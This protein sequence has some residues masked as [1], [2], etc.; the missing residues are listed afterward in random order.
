MSTGGDGGSGSTGASG[1]SGGAGGSAT[2]T[3]HIEVTGGGG[4]IAASAFA[5]GGSGG[6]GTGGGFL[7][8]VSGRGGDAAAVSTALGGPGSIEA[9]SI[10]IAGTPGD[11]L[12]GAVLGDDGVAHALASAVGARQ[13]AGRAQATGGSG[14]GA[15]ASAS[16]PGVVTGIGADV[17]Q[18]SGNRG[19]LVARAEIGGPATVTTASGTRSQVFARPE[20]TLVGGPPVE[21]DW[22]AGSSLAPRFAAGQID[23]LALGLVDDVETGSAGRIFSATQT[24]DFDPSAVAPGDAV[25]LQ[26][27]E[28]L[29]AAE[30]L[31]IQ[32]S[33][34]GT[35]LASYHL[36]GS[37]D[38]ADEQIGAIPIFVAGISASDS[39]RIV[40]GLAADVAGLES[41]AAKLVLYAGP[42]PEPCAAL[43]LVPLLLGWLA[44]GAQ[45]WTRTSMPFRAP[46]PES[47]VSTNF[48]TWARWQARD[49]SR[50]SPPA[51]AR[52]GSRFP[53]RAA[54]STA[55]RSSA[56][57]AA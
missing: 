31:D 50:A 14:S 46:D 22:L 28:L 57:R 7:A 48:T 3:A 8:A 12:N 45:D 17:T 9:T 41:F 5:N 30:V 38:G 11:A 42:V 39:A 19:S 16:S 29:G 52:A 37:L 25:F 32:L 51:R 15:S 56:S 27:T 36:E 13:A 10:A 47:G 2:S 53:R 33:L 21:G 40:L 34:D 24:F 49:A 35:L 26:F 6:S 23:V 44:R 20:P 43:L 4:L 55:A 18:T 1:G 54:G